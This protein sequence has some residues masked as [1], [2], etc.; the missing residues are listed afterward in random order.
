MLEAA[1]GG[2]GKRL[3]VLTH[4]RLVDTIRVHILLAV[5]ETYSPPAAFFSSSYTAQ[6]QASAISFGVQPRA[7]CWGAYFEQDV[8]PVNLRTNITFKRTLRHRAVLLGW[9]C[10]CGRRGACEVIGVS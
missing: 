1:I 9:E 5:F 2:S 10:W 3:E 7:G 4:V 8:N 6:H